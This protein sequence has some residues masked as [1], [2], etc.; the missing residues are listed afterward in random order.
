MVLNFDERAPI[1]VIP[2]PTVTICSLVKMMKHKYK[3]TNIS[4]NLSEKLS[5]NELS[6]LEALAHLCPRILFHGSENYFSNESI[7]DVIEDLAPNLDYSLRKCQWQ[8][9]DIRCSD[10]IVPM[11]TNNG[12]CFAFNALSSQDMYTDQANAIWTD[13]YNT[14]YRWRFCLR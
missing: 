2:F 13:T 10:Y 7:Y 11:M 9:K 12:L 6:Q 3:G 8:S 4:L 5:K 14:I 1:S